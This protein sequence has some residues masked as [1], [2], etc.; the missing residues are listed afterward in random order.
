MQSLFGRAAIAGAAMAIVGNAVLV[1]IDPAVSDDRV[2]YP[3]STGAFAAGQVWFAVTQ[4]L[5]A[6][7]HRGTG[8]VACGSETAGRPSV[9]PAWPWSGC[10]SR[11]LGELALVAGRLA[12][13]WTAAPPL[14]P[15]ASSD[16][17]CCWPTSG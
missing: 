16:W 7:R 13:T 4:A 3:L 17:V 14:L 6:P 9:R 12:R 2:S 8:P 1:L 10:G 15:A 5:M 11:F